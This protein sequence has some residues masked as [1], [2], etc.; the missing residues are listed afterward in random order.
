M[1]DKHMEG[2][3]LELWVTWEGRT[4]RGEISRNGLSCMI[5]PLPDGPG[6]QV[7][8]KYDPVKRGIL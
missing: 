7:L 8:T 6:L 3:S 2:K 4:V 5:L 1:R